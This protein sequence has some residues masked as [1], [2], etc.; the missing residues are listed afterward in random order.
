MQ[1]AFTVLSFLK[2]KYLFVSN[3]PNDLMNEN[4]K[5]VGG[6][7][8]QQAGD[9]VVCGVGINL[10]QKDSHWSSIEFDESPERLQ[11][12]YMILFLIKTQIQK[13]L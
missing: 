12:I 3:G 10:N 5:K 1:S 9:L 4:S 11:K 7:I 2:Q 6:I 13:I 8:C